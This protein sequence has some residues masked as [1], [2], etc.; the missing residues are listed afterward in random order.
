V[1]RHVAS[2]DRI[3][4]ALKTQRLDQPIK[5]SRSIVVSDSAIDTAITQIGANV[6]EIRC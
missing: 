5:Q 2:R 1:L 6:V 3:R 4:N